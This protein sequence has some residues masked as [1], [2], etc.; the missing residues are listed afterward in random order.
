MGAEKTPEVSRTGEQTDTVPTTEH[1]VAHY[2]SHQRWGLKE[3]HYPGSYLPILFA[4]EA[5]QTLFWICFKIVCFWLRPVLH[6]SAC[7]PFWSHFETRPFPLKLPRLWT[8]PL[9]TR[10]ASLKLCQFSHHSHFFGSYL[11]S[12]QLQYEQNLQ[13]ILAEFLVQLPSLAIVKILRHS[14][15]DCLE[16]RGNHLADLSGMNVVLKVTNSSQTS[17]MVQRNTSLRK[18]ASEKEQ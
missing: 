11:V 9:R 2:F 12:R 6:A 8:I 13:L 10:A 4:F 7:L 5:L 15:L 16:A 1:I 17:I 14:K 18:S 3:Q